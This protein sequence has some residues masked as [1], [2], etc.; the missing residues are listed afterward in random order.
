MIEIEVFDTIATAKAEC[1]TFLAAIGKEAV[2]KVTPV[3][4]G[5]LG[6]MIYVVEY[7]TG[8]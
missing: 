6:G 2:R 5:T 7:L 3:Y 8:A 4:E 1:N